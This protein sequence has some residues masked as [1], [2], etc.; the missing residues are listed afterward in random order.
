MLFCY[1]RLMGSTK[2]PGSMAQEER[3]KKMKAADLRRE[4]R[5]L[6]GMYHRELNKVSYMQSVAVTLREFL[7]VEERNLYPED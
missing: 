2:D 7:N 5:A 1:H 3:W 4:L 6:W